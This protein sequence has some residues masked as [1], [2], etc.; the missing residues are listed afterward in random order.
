MKIFYATYSMYFASLI[1]NVEKGL[2]KKWTKSKRQLYV[3]GNTFCWVVTVFV[4][5]IDRM[6]LR[7][8]AYI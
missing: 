7:S 1:A 8:K 3:V 2:L 6:K 4:I 5:H